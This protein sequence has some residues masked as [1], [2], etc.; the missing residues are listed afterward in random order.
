MGGCLKRL[1]CLIVIVVIA[2]A[3]WLTRDRWIRILPGTKGTS[4][5]TAATASGDGKWQPLAPEAAER[6]KRGIDA[7]NSPKGPVFVNLT[8]SDIAS[9][10]VSAAGGSLKGADSVEAAVIGDELF[11]RALVPTK[12][13]A[14]SGALGPLASLLNER[15]RVSLGG[16][17]HVIR[18][19]LSEF[20]IRDVTLRDIG[21]PR[22]AIPRLL[23]Q[24][25]KGKRPAGVAE[26]ALPVPTPPSLADVRIAN[27]K[28]TLYKT[29][30]GGAVA[31]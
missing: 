5:D 25:T 6:G 24:I 11:V 1:G 27:G 30:P 10:V 15:E 2:C 13:I 26:D 3:A 29:L 4:S 14:R 31:R 20:Q 7:L 16:T 8:A 9:Y 18:P 17:M 19:G 23:Q 12:D 28:V 21:I 22:P